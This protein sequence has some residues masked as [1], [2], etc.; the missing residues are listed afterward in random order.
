MQAAPHVQ[1]VRDAP[2][3][4]EDF[5]HFEPRLTAKWQE[6]RSRVR[7]V[8]L[9]AGTE[10]HVQIAGQ[11]HDVE[12]ESLADLLADVNLAE[13][14]RE[15]QEIREIEDALRRISLG[16]Y[17]TCVRCGRPI[18]RRRLEASPSVCRC[19][20]CQREHEK[21]RPGPPSTL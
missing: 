17:G 13:A 8:L 16:T 10:R 1:G 12:D 9:R 2:V 18:G 7:E 5:R 15:I 19:I 20:P 3:R 21:E 11:V 6:L 14:S 4:R